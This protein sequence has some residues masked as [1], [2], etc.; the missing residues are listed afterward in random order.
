MNAQYN[1]ESKP[2]HMQHRS[3]PNH[4]VKFAPQR[5]TLDSSNS[6][7]LSQGAAPFVDNERKRALTS[8]MYYSECQL[9]G[10]VPYDADS[11]AMEARQQYDKWWINSTYREESANKPR[12]RS[13]NSIVLDTEDQ[14]G[15]ST[16]NLGHNSAVNELTDDDLTV[17]N[18]LFDKPMTDSKI[19]LSIPIRDVSLS[20]RYTAGEISARKL[21][22]IEELKASG[23]DTTTS[24]FLSHLS[25]LHTSYTSRGWDARWKSTS[26][27][28]PS[29]PFQL[30]G[31][32]LALSKPSYTDCHG[33]TSKG[34]CLYSLGRLSFDMFRP[35]GLKCAIQGV[36]N[37]IHIRPEVPC[38]PLVCP[39]RLQAE[40]LAE[41][42]KRPAVRTYDIV[43]AL[44]IMPGQDRHGKDGDVNNNNKEYIVKRPIQALLTNHGYCI[45]DPNEVNRLTIWFTGGSLEAQD[46][47]DVDKEE[48]KQLFDRTL[49]PNR[50]ITEYARLIALKFLLGAEVQDDM[51]EE[52]IMSYHLKRPIGGHGRV[53][54]DI[55]YCDDTMRIVKGHNGSIFVVSRV[56]DSL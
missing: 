5:L 19:G 29:G 3:L 40:L 34:D 18:E 21:A 24:R 36:I 2:P 10:I 22:I 20:A 30:D 39:T 41:Q 17:K 23:G 26:N 33:T 1:N 38:R 6:P 12:K 32:W 14:H 48:W 46:D 4:R 15:S 47:D 9:N 55:L 16:A 45:P 53:F 54:I 7:L 11:A 35:T 37:S 8:A 56:P 43:V 51:N 31:K 27:N 49:L 44:T 42:S 13:R 25:V 28:C 52:G 50:T